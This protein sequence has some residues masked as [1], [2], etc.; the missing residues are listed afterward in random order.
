M[1]SE[2][3]IRDRTGIHPDAWKAAEASLCAAEQGR[4]WELHD[5][6]FA[7][8][9]ALTVEGVKEKAARLSLDRKA[10]SG[11]LDS[12]RH[13]DAVLADVRAGETVG[14]SGTP[15]LFINGR[16]VGGA[17]PFV[18]LAEIIDDELRTSDPIVVRGR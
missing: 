7:E 11:C 16:F 15:A 6:M 17:V 12:G 14:V 3:C 2:M 1:G 9:D 8:Q 4:F 18:E 10:F 5:L 13:H